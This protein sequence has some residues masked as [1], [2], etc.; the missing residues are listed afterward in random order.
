MAI[1]PTTRSHNIS[2]AELDD[3]ATTILNEMRKHESLFPYPDPDLRSFEAL[4]N[5]FREAVARAAYRDRLAIIA[6]N[7]KRKVLQ[8]NIRFLSFYVQTAA[9][10]DKGIILASGFVPSKPRRSSEHI[11]STADFRV[12]PTIGT[13]AV[14]LR[15]KAWRPARVYQFEYRKKGDGNPW[16]IELSSKSSCTIADLEVLAEYEFRVCYVGRSG[17]SPYSE[18][19]SSRAY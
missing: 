12:I 7:N 13:G 17:K 14:K 6:R 15:V 1:K 8:E 16:V 10:G 11:P 5:D 2:D 19:K 4:L 3:Y 18:V 9:K